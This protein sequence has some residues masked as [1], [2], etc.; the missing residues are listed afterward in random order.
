MSFFRKVF[1]ALPL[2]LLLPL[3]ACTGNAAPSPGASAGGAGASAGVPPVSAGGAGGAAP[4]SPT[5]VCN[6][7][8]LN[9]PWHYHGAA[10]T[11]TTSGTR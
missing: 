2:A 6:Q 4:V 9:A 8:I 3:A 7:P 10:G 5:R 1:L 11:F